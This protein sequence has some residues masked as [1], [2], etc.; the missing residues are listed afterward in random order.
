MNLELQTKLYV[1]SLVIGYEVHCQFPLN[2]ST[3]DS[4]APHSNPTTNNQPLHMVS[5]FF[6]SLF[7]P[8]GTMGRGRLTKLLV[9]KT[10]QLLGE[11]HYP[12]SHQSRL[13]LSSLRN[14]LEKTVGNLRSPGPVT[15][16]KMPGRA[17][18]NPK[19][20]NKTDC[21]LANPFNRHR[22]IYRRILRFGS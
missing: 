7:S 5:S 14:C 12:Q 2:F 13:G 20:L 16:Q 6:F 19:I 18:Q 21:I 10:H 8:T 1:T 9:Q 22:P 11:L 17:N 3:V 4:I 15:K